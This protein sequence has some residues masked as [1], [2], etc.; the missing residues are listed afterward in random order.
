M[1]YSVCS[2]E[3]EETVEVVEGF[4]R[5]HP[6]FALVNAKDVMPDG[7]APLVDESGLLRTLPHLHGTD[8]FFAAR[9]TR[10]G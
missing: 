2:L 1:V 4:L 5:R 8:G 6:E 9:F 3:P 7:C 10:T